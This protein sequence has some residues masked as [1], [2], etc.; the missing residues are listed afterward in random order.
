MTSALC[1]LSAGDEA[2]AARAARCGAPGRRSGSPSAI[3]PH[4]AGDVRGGPSTRAVETV[5]RGLAEHAPA[6]SARSASTITT[7]SR[8]ATCSRRSSAP[9]SRLARGAA[10]AVII[11]TREATDDTFRILRR[12][13][14]AGDCGACFTASPGTTPMARAALDIGFYVSFAGIVTFPK[15]ERLARGGA[16]RA[17]RSAPDRDRRAVPR[18]RPAPRASATSRRLSARVV[19]A[20]A[21]CGIDAGRGRGAGHAQFRTLLTRV[22]EAVRAEL[23][24]TVPT[25][26]SR[27]QR[28]SAL[29]PRAKVQYCGSPTPQTI[30]LSD[31]AQKLA[32]VCR[33]GAD[34]RTDPRGS[35]AVEQEFVRHIQSRVAL[36][37]EMGTLHPEERRQARAARGAADGGAALR[38]HGRPRGAQ[39]LGRGVHPHRDARPR[40]HHRRRRRRA[41]AGWPCTRAGATTSPSCSATTST[42][43]R[44]RWR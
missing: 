24:V 6:P 32:V 17:G 14:G 30:P 42:S 27:C 11:H 10:A 23:T 19:E 9:R 36:I 22:A 40:R 2:E 28:L 37:P 21:G 35:R 44:W 7:I 26:L 25:N 5:R 12:G 29:T 34:L 41:A 15:A 16:D 13:G 43:S 8:R 38:L 18:A 31:T 4:Q 39:R 33:P 1:I 3:H 20:L